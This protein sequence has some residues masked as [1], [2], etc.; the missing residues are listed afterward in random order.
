ML[1]LNHKM[2]VHQSARHTVQPSVGEQSLLHNFEKKSQPGDFVSWRV[3]ESH[4]V[5]GFWGQTS[6]SYLCQL[7]CLLHLVKHYDNDHFIQHL[8]VHYYVTLTVKTTAGHTHV[9]QIHIYAEMSPFNDFAM[10]L[11]YSKLHQCSNFTLFLETYM[12]Y[13]LKYVPFRNK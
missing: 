7:L 4:N 8:S 1:G 6:R 11:A 12:L 10:F 3:E 13:Y 9:S 2:P 5:I